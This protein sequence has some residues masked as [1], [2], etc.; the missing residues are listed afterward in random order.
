MG[1]GSLQLLLHLHGRVRSSSSSVV[2]RSVTPA[3]DRGKLSPHPSEPVC[4]FLLKVTSP[5]V[6]IS[7]IMISWGIGQSHGALISLSR[8]LLTFPPFVTSAQSWHA[9]LPST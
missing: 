6:W 5:P 1:L 2:L 8:P 9:W 4:T 3:T 7:R